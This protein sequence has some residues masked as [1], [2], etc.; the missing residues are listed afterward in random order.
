MPRN[1]CYNATFSMRKGLIASAV[2]IDSAD[3]QA[4]K[5]G[6]EEIFAARPEFRGFEVWELNR[7]VHLHLGGASMPVSAHG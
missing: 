2:I 4:G 6:S 3:D 7:R 5:L 1:H